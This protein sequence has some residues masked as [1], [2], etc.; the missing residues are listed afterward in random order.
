MLRSLFVVSLA[1]VVVLSGCKVS[2]TPKTLMTG[3]AEKPRMRRAL[4]DGEYRLYVAEGARP[5]RATGEPIASQH[6]DRD[7][8]IGFRR[9]GGTWSAVA[10][11]QVI[12]LEAGRRYLWQMRP[13]PGQTD[14]GKTAALVIVIGVGI[15]IVGGSHAASMAWGF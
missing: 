7:E 15:I 13:D 10:G 9:A 2:T 14:R 3:S 4:H 12:P 6:L 1:A 8:R 5:V 11:Q